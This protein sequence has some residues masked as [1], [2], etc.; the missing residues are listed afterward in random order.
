MANKTVNT[1]NHVIDMLG[2]RERGYREA[3][4]DIDNNAYRQVFTELANQSRELINRLTEEVTRFGGSPDDGGSAAGAVH[5]AWMDLKTALSNND[6][7]AVL[8]EC[9]RGEDRAVEVYENA[10]NEEIDPQ[11]HE[12]LKDQ[13][14][15]V[16]RAHESIRNLRDHEKN[17]PITS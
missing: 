17:E 14:R 16:A 6:K 10:L 5:R 2:N 13:Y 12:M 11:A 1:L 15:T 8:E 3:A 7:V 9:E 4:E